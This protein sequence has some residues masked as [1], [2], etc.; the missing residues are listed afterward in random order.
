L[1]YSRL[2]HL[3]VVPTNRCPT[4]AEHDTPEHMLLECNRAKLV[5]AKLMTKIPKKPNCTMM[6]YAIGINDSKSIL[7]VKAEILKYMMHFLELSA[8]QVLGRALTYLKL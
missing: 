1:S 8:E 3:G 7:M 4:R 6:H 2:I 5:W